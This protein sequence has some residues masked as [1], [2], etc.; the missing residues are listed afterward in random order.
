MISNI[1]DYH[2][3]VHQLLTMVIRNLKSKLILKLSVYIK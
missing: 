2:G 3:S 1:S